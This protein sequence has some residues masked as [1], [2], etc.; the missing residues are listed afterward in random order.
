MIDVLLATYCPNRKWLDL[1]KRSILEQEDVSINLI[2]RED[3]NCD[4]CCANFSA[5]LQLSLSDYAAFADQDDI[6]LPN[7]LKTCLAKMREMEKLWGKDAPLLVFSDATVVDS[8]L[9]TLSSS[10]FRR[11]KVNPCRNLPRQLVLQNTAY[12][13]TML[14]NAALRRLICPI[15]AD[16]VMHDHWTMLVASV[17]GHIAYVNEPLLLYRQ[18]G[19]NIFGGPKVGWYYFGRKILQGRQLLRKRIFADIGQIEA[20]VSHFGDA[21]PKEFRALVGL[22]S[23]PYLCRVAILLSNRVFKNGLLRNLGTLLVV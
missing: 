1:Q 3:S 8:E 16:A 23:K 7:K 22:R 2:C 14:I 11:I 19:Q 17:F 10:L 13:N 12:G 6:W 9:Q 4:G 20:F 15:P 18:H 21:A 5:L